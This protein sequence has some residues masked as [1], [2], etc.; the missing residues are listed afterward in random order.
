MITP[1]AA[2]HNLL[3]HVPP[4]DV[5][6]RMYD[7]IKMN[8]SIADEMLSTTDVPFQLQT[9][10][11]THRLFIKCDFNRDLDSYRSPYTSKYIPEL[12]DGVQPPEPLRQME[13]L[14]D[15]AIETLKQLYYNGKGV[16]NCYTWE[17]SETEFGIGVFIRKRLADGETTDDGSIISGEIDS[18]DVFTVSRIGDNL[19]RYEQ[20]SSV[21]LSLHLPLDVGE[22]LGVSGSLGSKKEKDL[23]ATCPIDHVANV[24]EMVERSNERFMSQISNIY[25]GK[26]RE[27]LQKCRS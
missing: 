25:V 11:D 4:K 13:V 22:P 17:I 23:T 27:I 1:E 20:V 8:P 6:D 10:P 21:L 26:M 15:T 7:V 24:F 19:F 5:E 18:S 3:V 2:A 16:G 9:C 14:A 12:P